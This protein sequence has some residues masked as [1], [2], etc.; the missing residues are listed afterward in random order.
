MQSHFAKNFQAAR[1]PLPSIP[2]RLRSRQ[3]SDAAMERCKRSARIVLRLMRRTSCSATLGAAA[4][5][6]H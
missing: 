4:R 2:R 1:R 6:A 3:L 5:S